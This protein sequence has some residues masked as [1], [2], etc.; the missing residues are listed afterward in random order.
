MY[1]NLLKK[2]RLKEFEIKA[3]IECFTE[4]F[5]P[6]DHIWVFG[7]RADMQKRGGDLDLYIETN[8][9]A[10]KA[11]KTKIKFI[12]TLC[13]TIG[14]QKIDVVLHIMQDP[15]NLAIYTVAKSEGVKLI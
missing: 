4:L 2:V 13:D 15:I 14:D 7:S 12:N 6:E 1:E 5:L 10:T 9:A 3:I 11:Y 8:I